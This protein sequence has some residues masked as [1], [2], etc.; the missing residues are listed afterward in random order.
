MSID[1]RSTGNGTHSSSPNA[2]HVAQCTSAQMPFEPSGRCSEM[3]SDASSIWRS[4]VTSSCSTDS[5][6]ELSSFSWSASSL[7]ARFVK[8]ANTVKPISSS[9]RARNQASGDSQPVIRHTLPGADTYNVS[10]K[11]DIDP[12]WLTQIAPSASPL[13]NGKREWS[14]RSR[15]QTRWTVRT[16]TP[17]RCA[18][19]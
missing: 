11:Y 2:I 4:D 1:L 3:C 13:G 16:R 9:L 15:R 12:R 7:P 5:R 6:P 17:A 19:N 14:Q 10:F 8:P 18:A